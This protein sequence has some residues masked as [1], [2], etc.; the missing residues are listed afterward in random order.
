MVSRFILQR[1]KQSVVILVGI[2]VL[3]F[4]MMH[5]TG[6]PAVLMLPLDA[7]PEAIVTFRASMG[8]DDPL[9]VQYGRFLLSALQGDFGRS[10]RHQQPSLQLILERM[11]A[12]IDRAYL[13]SHGHSHPRCCTTRCVDG[14]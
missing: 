3:V 1:L 14:C 5:L 7:S 4:C 8:F 2:S 10:L 9:W 11:P 13:C 12:T 6:D